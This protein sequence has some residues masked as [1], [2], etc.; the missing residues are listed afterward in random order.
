MRSLEAATLSRI[1]ALVTLVERDEGM[2]PAM[3][4]ELESI[5][6]ADQALAVTLALAELVLAMCDVLG[7][8]TDTDPAYI[9]QRLALIAAEAQ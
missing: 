8:A 9:R 7:N 3:T 6:A 2:G 4:A 1:V 5:A